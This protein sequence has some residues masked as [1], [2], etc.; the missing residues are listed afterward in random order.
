[1]ITNVSLVTLYVT[2]QENHRIRFV[3]MAGAVSTWIGDDV[4]ESRDGAVAQARFV[5]PQ[6]LARDQNG[7]IYV[8]D[9]S[10][11]YIRRIGGGQ[12]TTVAGNGTAGYLDRIDPM[13]AS[14]FGLE[15]IDVTPEGDRLYIADGDLGEDLPYH[16]VRRL[17]F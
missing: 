3:T 1:M 11:H 13:Q 15:G 6:G 16:R 4:A 5:K 9:P 8:S 7:V 17:M 10:G 12:V 2:D 14:F